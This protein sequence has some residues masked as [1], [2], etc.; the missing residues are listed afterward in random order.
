MNK[1]NKQVKGMLTGISSKAI[2]NPF[3]RFHHLLLIDDELTLAVLSNDSCFPVEI[4]ATI[5]LQYKERLVYNKLY[6]NGIAHTL[7]VI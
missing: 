1:E 5:E 4:G 3:Y 7:R 2:D 6:R